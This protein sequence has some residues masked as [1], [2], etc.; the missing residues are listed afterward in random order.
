[1]VMVT[2]SRLSVTEDSQCRGAKSVVDKSP[3]KLA[4]LV[5]QRGSAY[6]VCRPRHLTLYQNCEVRHQMPSCCFILHP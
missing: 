3:P 4:R 6:S 5:I 1:M 2:S